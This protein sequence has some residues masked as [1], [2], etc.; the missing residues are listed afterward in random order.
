MRNLAGHPNS[1][2]LCAIELQAAGITITALDRPHGEPG[3]LVGGQV[4][5]FK[6]RRA[7]VYWCV[8][9]KMSEE[10]ARAINLAPREPTDRDSK[11]SGGEHTWGSVIRVDGF[12]GGRDVDGSVDSWHID[13]E[14]GL[15]FFAAKLREFGYDKATPAAAA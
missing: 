9:G 8:S 2:A 4:G 12:A 5:P 14:D 6:F 3:S 15:A 1:T 13:T 11:Y 7:W 10:H